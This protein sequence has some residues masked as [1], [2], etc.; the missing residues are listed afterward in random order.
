M[1]LSAA[2]EEVQPASGA[3]GHLL[4]CHHVEDD[5]S[6]NTAMLAESIVLYTSE[7]ILLL[8][9]AVTLSI[10]TS[11]LVP[12]ATVHAH[13]ITLPRPCFRNEMSLWNIILLF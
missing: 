11:E 10:N 7:F 1:L 2:V 6:A 3:T 8:R 9:S 12:L 4:H 13:T 5:L